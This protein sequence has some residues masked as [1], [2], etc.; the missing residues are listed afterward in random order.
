M[1]DPIGPIDPV[2][3]ST[4]GAIVTE[5]LREL[6]V[7]GQI[8]PGTQLS[9]VELAARFGVSRGPVREALQRLLQEGLLRRDARRGIGVPIMSDDDIADLYFVREAIESRAIRVVLDKDVGAVASV[10]R[11]RVREMRAA[12]RTGDWNRV[13]DL[14]MAFH[15]F[16]VEAAGSLRLSRIYAAIV[17]ETRACLNVTARYPGRESIVDEHAEL[18]DLIE[19]R[20]EPGLLAALSRHLSQSRDRLV[21]RDAAGG[22][23]RRGRGGRGRVD[24]DGLVPRGGRR[25][26]E[27][28]RPSDRATTGA[29]VTTR[30]AR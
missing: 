24:R 17:D 2:R 13:A 16:L 22:P 18:A 29:S 25:S 30:R 20:D 23:V 9:E 3:R 10:L 5:R 15:S 21:A 28:A 4:L 1:S 19:R 8:A 27:S 11:E 6:V 14:D 7:H 26:R 12:A